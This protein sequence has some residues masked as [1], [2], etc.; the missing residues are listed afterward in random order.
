[1]GVSWDPAV[2]DVRRED[3]RRTGKR[4]QPPCCARGDTPRQQRQP[5]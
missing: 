1:M 5:N 4:R 3:G 2:R